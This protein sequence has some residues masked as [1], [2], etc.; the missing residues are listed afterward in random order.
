MDVDLSIFQLEI[1]P[2]V[3]NSRWRVGVMNSLQSTMFRE[4]DEQAR[5]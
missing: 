5:K 3:G 2:V 1:F 4:I